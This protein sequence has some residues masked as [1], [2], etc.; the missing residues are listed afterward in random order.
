M[1]GLE[2]SVDALDSGAIKKLA[3]HQDGSAVSIDDVLHA[4]TEDDSFQAD[5]TRDIAGCGFQAVRFETPPATT[6]TLN[7]PFECVLV[8][9]PGLVRTP[10]ASSFSRQ[11]AA[12]DPGASVIV[13]PNLG[14]DAT[15]IVPRPITGNDP[16]THLIDF[17]NN[18]PM[19]QVQELWSCV[20]KAMLSLVGETPLWLST[21]G[22]GVPWLHVRIDKRPKYYTHKPYTAS[23]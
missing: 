5:L 2:L 7:S 3:V 9:S 14:R 23:A 11:F 21:A 8:D 17:L 16:Y 18:A 10:N 6:S 4:L 22:G 1:G 19:P 13:F 15:M 20:G 12:A